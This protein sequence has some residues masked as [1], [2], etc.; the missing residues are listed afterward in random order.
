[1]KPLPPGSELFPPQF[2][3]PPEPVLND[4]SH[5]TN[6]ICVLHETTIYVV[7]AFCGLF[8]LHDY[9]LCSVSVLWSVCSS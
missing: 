1:M 8:V 6:F 2:S 3:H 9:N 5:K 7:L 4:H